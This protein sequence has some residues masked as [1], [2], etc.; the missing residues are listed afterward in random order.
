[1]DLVLLLVA[2]GIGSLSFGQL[3]GR[4]RGFDLSQRDTPGASGTF[5]QLGPGWGV[6]VALL[7]MAKGA[8][9]AWLSTHTA[10]SWALAGMGMAVVAGLYWM[11]FWRTHRRYW[12]PIPVGAVVGY[13][14]VLLALWSHP[15]GFWAFLLVSVVVALRGLRLAG[16]G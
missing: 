8:L 3:A 9:V 10:S 14:Y 6:A 7:D 12:Y 15:K 5:R 11:G 13:L 4:L 16:R 2:Y 1:M